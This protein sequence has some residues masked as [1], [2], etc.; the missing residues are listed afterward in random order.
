[1]L[2]NNAGYVFGLDIG[3]R[4]MVGTVGYKTKDGRFIVAAQITREHKTRAMLD[5]QIHDI[6]K[7][8]ES[9]KEIKEE[10]EKSLAMP[11]KE[12]CIAAAGRVL[13]TIDRKSVV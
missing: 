13:K 9:I 3:T 7:V 8:S 6:A 2:K 11:L 5:G 1:M 4:N 12:V 10:L